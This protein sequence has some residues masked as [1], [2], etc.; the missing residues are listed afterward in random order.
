MATY[1]IGDVHACLV[2]LERLLTKIAPTASDSFIFIGD[3]VGRGPQPWEVLALVKQ[4][5]ATIILGNHD[6]SFIAT[7]YQDITKLADSQQELLGLYQAAEFAHYH[8][9]TKTLMVH[10]GVWHTWSLEQTLSYAQ[11]TKNYILRSDTTSALQRNMY[12]NQEDYWEES[13]NG[14]PRYRCLMNIFTRVRTLNSKKHMD[15]NYTGP[16]ASIPTGN[17]PWYKHTSLT[18]NKVIF[19]H[20]A[21]LAGISSH[22]QCICIDAG[23]VWG[24]A[25]LAYRLEDAVMFKVNAPKST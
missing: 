9:A 17:T 7:A 5:K 15:F 24:G 23:Y 13:L 19:G 8:E 16:L 2:G 3:L 20:W 6:L 14:W 18:C 25:M 1:V 4:L 12:A 21:A 11:E 22:K 10:A